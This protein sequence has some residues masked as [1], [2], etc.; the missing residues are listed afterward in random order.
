MPDH[1]LV[2]TPSQPAYDLGPEHPFANFRQQPLFDLMRQ[3]GWIDE[4]EMI[5]PE[6]A[7]REELELAHE[8]HYIDFVE[9][10]ASDHTSDEIIREAPVFGLGTA[11]NP[12]AAGQH[13]AAAAVAGGTIACARAVAEGRAKRAFNPG[14]GLHHAMPSAASGFCIYND[15]VI[16]IRAAQ[17]AGIER[18]AYVDYDVHHGDG[19]EY[20]FRDDPNVLTVSFHET[21]DVR[22]PFT[23]KVEDRGGPSAPGSAI[24]VPMQSFTGDESWQH[25]VEHTLRNAFE[26]FRPQMIVTQHGA[27]PHWE[28]PLAELR[29]TTR[30]FEFAARLSR[31]L[32]EQHA[33]GRWVATGGGGYQPVRVLPRAWSIVWAVMSDREI[34]TRVA[35]AW[36]ER[37]QQRSAEPLAERFIDEPIEFPGA[38]QAARANEWTL[39]RLSELA[40]WNSSTD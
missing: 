15:L 3:H 4:G 7:T 13:G 2:D 30:S 29:L 28:D 39:Q 8:P 25:C 35:D 12:I 27:D 1:L 11:D 32:A 18:V 36:I 9:R 5:R 37:W 14:G 6:S 33:D 19:V 23:G 24:N 17:R 40:G 21:P 22:W 34:P 31:E 16:G 20:A 10:L 38:G 26:R